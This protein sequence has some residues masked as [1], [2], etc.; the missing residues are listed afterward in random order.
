[1]YFQHAPAIWTQFPALKAGT[2]VVEGIDPYAETGTDV[3][4]L[5]DRARARLSAS[6]EEGQMPEIDAWRRVYSQ[7]GLK[8][9]QYRCAAESLLRRFRKENSMPSF[10]PLVD[11]C[12]AL[13]LAYATPIAV[14]DTAH[15]TGGIEV[16][17]AKGTEDHLAFSGEIEKPEVNEVIFCDEADHAHSRRWCFRQ[18]KKSVVTDGTSTALIVAEAHHSTAGED[19]RA[20]VLELTGLLTKHW[21]APRIHQMLTA[22]DPRIEI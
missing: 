16:R 14:Y 2:L 15:I 3:N 18:S 4:G 22:A 10:H 12:N 1:M 6:P 21:K 11:L 7:M 17:H 19:V 20:L 9:T 8:P 5:Y 13:S